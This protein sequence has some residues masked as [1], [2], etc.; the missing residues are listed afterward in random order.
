[1]AR[2]CSNNLKILLM[3]LLLLTSVS[4]YISDVNSVLLTYFVKGLL[5]SDFKVSFI[6]IPRK[7]INS[8]F[9]K[10]S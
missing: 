4:V 7:F 10:P 5:L 3:F 1:M 8:A 2:M 9:L 6:S